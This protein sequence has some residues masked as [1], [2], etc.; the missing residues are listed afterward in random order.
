MLH[1]IGQAARLSGV[2]AAN[3]RYYEK[4]GLLHAHTRADNDYRLYTD[5]AVHRLRLVRLCRALDMS[6]DEVR[7][8]LALD[9]EGPHDQHSACAT[10]DA[11]L[12]HVRQRLAELHALEHELR[13]LR[14]R[15]DGSGGD[16]QVMAALHARAD[17]QPVPELGSAEAT[18][19]AL[20][21]GPTRRHV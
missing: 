2:S 13:S 9:G 4:Q 3:I 15:C 19:G 16:C 12:G 17:A 20:P 11:H 21:T 1:R 5:D 7:A 14:G 10:L 8:V 6:L 18:A